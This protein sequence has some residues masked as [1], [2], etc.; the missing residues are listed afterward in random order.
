MAWAVVGCLVSLWV[1]FVVWKNI[2]WVSS[3]SGFSFGSGMTNAGNV[4]AL[5]GVLAVQLR[6]EAFRLSEELKT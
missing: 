5:F 6:R 4:A 3:G 1:V 2:I